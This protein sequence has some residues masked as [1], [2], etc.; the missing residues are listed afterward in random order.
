MFATLTISIDLGFFQ[1]I[2]R[3]KYQIMLKRIKLL[4]IYLIISTKEMQLWH[5]ETRGYCDRKNTIKT[6]QIK[7]LLKREITMKLIMK[8]D[9]MIDMKIKYFEVQRWLGKKK[10]EHFSPND[11]CERR[12]C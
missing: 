2:K 6:K 10:S 1:P 9:K 4:H 7:T 12:N 5:E 8:V 11:I 3:T